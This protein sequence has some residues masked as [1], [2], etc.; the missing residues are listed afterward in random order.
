LAHGRD[1]KMFGHYTTFTVFISQLKVMLDVLKAVRVERADED[2]LPKN[3][4]YETA[5]N[6]NW[7]LVDWPNLE[8]SQAVWANVVKRE[9]NPKMDYHYDPRNHNTHCTAGHVMI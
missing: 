6:V 8:K 9:S 2:G 5:E 3:L 1:W 4:M 7:M